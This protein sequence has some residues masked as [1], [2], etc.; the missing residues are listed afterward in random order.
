MGTHSMEMDSAGRVVVT[1]AGTFGLADAPPLAQTLAEA[2]EHS[3]EAVVL[4][5]GAVEQCGVIFFQMLFA[6]A[7]QASR[8]G[9]R[10]VL[11]R[12]FPEGLRRDAEQLG[13][14]HKDLDAFILSEAL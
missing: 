14:S 6:L 10:V 9:K 2:L 8:D 3:S 13:I 1:L 11:A 5:P 12:P 7:K 4:S